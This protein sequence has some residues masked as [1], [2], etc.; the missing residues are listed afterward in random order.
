[1]FSSDRYSPKS[2]FISRS[3]S[4]TRTVVLIPLRPPLLVS[5]AAAPTPGRGHSIVRI[6]GQKSPEVHRLIAG[7]INAATVLNRFHADTILGANRMLRMMAISAHILQQ[8]IDLYLE[9]A[10]PSGT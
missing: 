8:A 2:S 7:L 9:K 4:T 6:S 5:C 3:S 1:M 10:Y